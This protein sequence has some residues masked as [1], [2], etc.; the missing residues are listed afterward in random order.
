MKIRL[1]D[2]PEDLGRDIPLN[3]GE[4]WLMTILKTQLAEEAK[5]VTGVIGNVHLDIL[6]DNVTLSGKLD[7]THSPLCARCGKEITITEH[8][9]LKATLAPLFTSKQDRAKHE[10]EEEELT[11]DDLEFSFY[12]GDSVNLE[13]I[14]NDEVAMHLPLNYF[15]HDDCKGLCPI[16]RQDLNHGPCGC[17]QTA[18]PSP[19]DA[20]KQVAFIPPA[21]EPKKKKTKQ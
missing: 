13:T 11:L 10:D 21:N 9:P 16:C 1:I 17:P 8:V 20:L 18:A 14:L 7:F 4:D 3:V 15:C 5:P 6:N 19:W 12:D 2:I